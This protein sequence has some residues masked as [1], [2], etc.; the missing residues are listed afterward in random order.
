MQSFPPPQGSPLTLGQGFFVGSPHRTF[1]A[2][3]FL[4]IIA[5]RVIGS[6]PIGAKPPQYGI[7]LL[8]HCM[9]ESL[10]FSIL[11]S[12]IIEQKK[13]NFQDKMPNQ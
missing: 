7:K 1:I 12:A 6:F 8:G 9:L 11:L 13:H 4:S 3:C 5:Y 2:G 10:V